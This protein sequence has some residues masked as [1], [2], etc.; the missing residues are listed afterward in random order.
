MD[1]TV[2]KNFNQAFAK[3]MRKGISPKEVGDIGTYYIVTYN[4]IRVD[5]IYLL[6]VELLHD[7]FGLET[8]KIIELMD[9]VDSNL[10][11]CVDADSYRE[12]SKT[13]A[14]RILDKTGIMMARYFDEEDKDD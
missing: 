10:K 3:C 13:L 2:E 8:D 7:E 14:Q 11:D 12:M 4:D 6:W 9:R 5:T 1:K